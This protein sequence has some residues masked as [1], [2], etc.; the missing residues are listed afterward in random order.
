VREPPRRLRRKPLCRAVGA[1]ALA[2]AGWGWAVEHAGSEPATLS[3]PSPDQAREATLL[4]AATVPGGGASDIAGTASALRDPLVAADA[5]AAGEPLRFAQAG[6]AQ[7]SGGASPA[8]ATGLL[9]SIRWNLARPLL[10]WSGLVGVDY[11]IDKADDIDARTL[12]AY[13]TLL[14]TAD[15]YLWQ[16]WLAQ[17]QGNLALSVFYNNTESR[18]DG[19]GLG[20][21][22]EQTTYAWSG[23]GRVGVFPYSRFPFEAY[24]DVS[25]SRTNGTLFEQN[26]DSLRYGIRQRYQNQVGSQAYAFSWDHSILDQTYSGTPNTK[27]TLDIVILNGSYAMTN[28]S[29]GAGVQWDRNKR[30]DGFSQTNLN[31]VAQHNWLP[32]AQWNV[33]SVLSGR[34]QQVKQPSTPRSDSTFAQ[35][36]SVANWTP[37]DLPMSGFATVRL[38][39]TSTETGAGETDSNEAS[40]GVAGSYFY[41]R[42]TTFSGSFSVNHNEIETFTNT[43]LTGYYGADTIPLGQWQY[44]WNASGTVNNIA[45]GNAP[46]TSATA[47]VGQSLGR[48]LGQWWGGDTNLGLNLD[49]GTTAG[50]GIFQSTSSVN[51]GANLSWARSFGATQATASLT[52]SDF[53]TFGDVESNFALVNAQATLNGQLS[54]NSAWNGNVTL[55]WTRDERDNPLLGPTATQILTDRVGSV[56]T[57][58]NVSVGYTNFRVFDVPRLTFTSNLRAYANDFERDETT[59]VTQLPAFAGLG[60]GETQESALEW[61]NRLFYTIGKTELELR[62]ILNTIDVDNTGPSTR[63]QVGI[64]IL[65]RLGF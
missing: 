45:G 65:R 36:F 4:A 57:Y 16:P 14:G 33:N 11:F 5:P 58:F 52:A 25:D 27:D 2:W 64:R 6:A 48:P 24:F 56:Q 43:V 1:I 19:G 31:A 53:M 41:N 32:S 63:W 55:Q 18:D 23:G 49:I 13:T 7:S 38:A 12:N 46:G 51:V 8:G 28:Q 40:A 61:D 37:A 15:T 62:A 54:R 35:V 30:N 9:S 3:T 26:Q 22:P 47:A 21:N 20:S 60:S 10:R 17:L 59:L 44:F 39:N 42:N 34:D 50:S 29:V